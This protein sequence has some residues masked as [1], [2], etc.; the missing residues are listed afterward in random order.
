MSGFG[1][2]VKLTGENE[3]RKALSQITQSLRVVSAEM[4]VASSSFDAGE[5]SQKELEKS[6]KELK[7][8]L[9]IE[10]EG[11]SGLKEKL[12]DLE[13]E[14][15]KTQ[16][17]HV[18][19]L[20]EYDKESQKL[21]QIE[22]D[23]GTSSQEY[24]A[25]EKV[26]ADLDKEL[27]KSTKEYDAQGNAINQ[28]RIQT[29]N[30]ESTINQTSIAID[31][32]GKS[33]EESKE[34]FT[35]M[36]G[37]LSNLATDVIRSVIDGIKQLGQAFVDVGKEAVSS[38][39]EFEQL[40]G[41]VKKIFGDD[42]AQA[43]IENSQ[44]AFKTAGLSA[45]EYMETVTGFSASLIQSLGGDTEKAVEVSDRAIRDMSD[46]ANTFGTDMASIQA[47]YNNIAKGQFSTLDN[48]KLGYGGTKEEAQRLIE[49]ASK[50][51]DV[52]EELGITVDANSLDFANMT[53]A[54]S[55]IQ[56]SMGVM[57]TTAKESATTIE[58]STNSMKS[59]W[60]NML[61]GLA[62]ENA[63]FETLAS[64]F[65]GTLITEDGQG[66]VIGTLVP[67]I[68]TVIEGMSNAI[69]T[70]LPQLMST[71]VPIIQQNLPVIIE[72]ISGALNTLVTLFPQIVD[73][74][75]SLI[76]MIVSE[77]G[78]LAPQLLLMGI[79]V[80]LSLA[81]GIKSAIPELVAQIP[82]IISDICDIIIDWLPDIIDAGV[83]IA[84]G[85]LEGLISAIPVI[86][87]DLPRLINNIISGL[88]DAIPL[89]IDAG[90]Q[91]FVALVDNL[92][93]II[94]QIV[95]VLPD[96][97]SGII[98][99]IV[100]NI[101][102][103]VSAGVRLFTALITNLPAIIV[104]IVSAIPSIIEGIITG[105]EESIPALVEVGTELFGQPWEAI[106]N[107]FNETVPQAFENVK[108]RVSEFL[109]NVVGFFTSIPDKINEFI[110]KAITFI[111]ELP[112]NLGRI[113]GEAIGKLL[114]FYLD[115]N[116]WVNTKIKAIIDGVVDFFA[117]LPTRIWEW[118][119][120]TINNI[121]L[122]SED[123]IKKAKETGEN[124]IKNIIDFVMT[125]PETLWDWLLKSFEK[126]GQFA[127]DI[128]QKGKEGAEEMGRN[129]IETLSELP[130]KIFDVGVNI[131]EGLWNGI[132]SMGS[133]LK[134]KIREF[135]NGILDGMKEALG[136]QSPSKVFRDEVGK[137]I[138]QGIGVGFENEMQNVAKDMQN[139]IPTSFEMGMSTSG[140]ASNGAFVVAE[141][142][143]AF[144]EALYQVKIEMDDEAMGQFVDKT[145]TNLV[146]S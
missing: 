16:S 113:L 69:Q 101:P 37:V 124:F 75:S 126:V 9:D 79:R 116:E 97:V 71:I 105:I 127:V 49:D 129:L 52:M 91:L 13:S 123:V 70:L 84:M 31:K 131:V 78:N 92:P 64:N 27:T 119:T 68:T 107:F 34:G 67:R 35:V 118:L 20:Q 76:P 36:K 132:T 85:L 45:N 11:L 23:L 19:L 33:A 40:E 100:E 25:Q 14:Y 130:K 60:A 18:A 51:T 72:A 38:Y 80:L 63:D 138:A 29:A 44:N 140:N 139:A 3:Y 62:D 53:N 4:K 42:M 133:W 66:G 10:K 120:N 81:D 117:T 50:M 104:G 122:W 58:G 2:S 74:L 143:D 93:T 110:Q 96:L 125:L 94:E 61:T 17:K 142:V 128:A 114:Q 135:A 99:G 109:D 86:L 111:Q 6:A 134:D 5:K 145:V 73:A 7:A 57:G 106:K 26:V 103:I 146:Y 136:I 56:A 8:S 48:L 112:Y 22:K 12:R 98:T 102:L 1:G 87:A 28:M 90:I 55:V 88:L 137:Y 54:I 82:Q 95:A 89:I 83:S 21:E 108:A 141:M 15:A 59:A 121:I 41:G 77:L 32:M 24:K 65:I 30:A 46:N 39:A 144:K 115:A 47:V 43:V